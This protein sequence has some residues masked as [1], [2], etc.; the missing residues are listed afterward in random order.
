MN[1]LKV[2]ENNGLI[3]IYETSKGAKVV[4]ARELHQGLESK[5]DFSDWA[6]SRMSECD[7]VEDKDFTIIL[8]KSTGGRPS[9]EYLVKLDTAKEMAIKY[10]AA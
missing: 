9:R 2:I 3:K 8:G 10:R 5:Q 1:D 4:Q 6:K 7:A